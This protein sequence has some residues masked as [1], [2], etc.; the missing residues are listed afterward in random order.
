LPFIRFKSLSS[1][2]TLHFLS[3]SLFIV[4][5][6]YFLSNWFGFLEVIPLPSRSCALE[7]LGSFP[8][9]LYREWGVSKKKDKKRNLQRLNETKRNVCVVVIW[10]NPRRDTR[11]SPRKVTKESHALVCVFVCVCVYVCRKREREKGRK[12]REAKRELRIFDDVFI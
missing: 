5:V 3:I 12:R 1:E 4:V 8:P 10:L 2:T 9:P 7:W 6:H 11:K